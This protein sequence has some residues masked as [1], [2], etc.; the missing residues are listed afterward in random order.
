VLLLLLKSLVLQQAWMQRRSA[1]CFL[2]IQQT[3]LQS[4]STASS[5]RLRC[6]Q[7]SLN[8]AAVLSQKQMH[9]PLAQQASSLPVCKSTSWWAAALQ[10]QQ[11]Q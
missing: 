8:L 3:Q 11:L 1:H 5:S 6:G 2:H 4:P 10:Q 9:V 7:G